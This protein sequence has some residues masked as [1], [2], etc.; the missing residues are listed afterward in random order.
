VSEYLSEKE[1]WEQVKAWFRENGPWIVCGILLAGLGVGGWR[2][3]Q[4]HTDRVALDA[5]VRYGQILSAF[6]SGDRTRGLELIDELQ[7]DHA[8]SPYVD[9][10]NLAAA[11]LFVDSNEL[12]QAAERL[13]TVM[14]DSRDPELVTIARLRLARIQ[15]SLGKP[16]AALATLGP[17]QSGAFASRYHEIRG[18]AYYARGDKASALSEYRAALLAAGP[19][20]AENNVLNLKIDDLTEE[21]PSPSSTAISSAATVSHASTAVAPR[22]SAAR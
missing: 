12:E 2:W 21:T 18:D 20:L 15:I 9:Q 3:W 17:P 1:Q 6:N 14:R 7:R 8:G 13:E 11:R 16:D 10:A 5:N 22:S 19:S 4:A